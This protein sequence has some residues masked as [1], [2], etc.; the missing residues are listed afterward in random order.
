[1]KLFGRTQHEE[2]A[3]PLEGSGHHAF[4]IAGGS[5]LQLP[6]G[7]NAAFECTASRASIFLICQTVA[8]LPVHLFAR[9]EGNERERASDHPA[10]KLIAHRAA[11]WM[12]AAE[13]RREMT[14]DA[15]W[16]GNA[17][18]RVIRI[19]DAVRELQRIRPDAITLMIDQDSGEV[20]YKLRLADGGEELL[21]Y[22]EILHLQALRARSTIKDIMGAIELALALEGHGRKVFKNGAMPSGI[23]RVPTKLS[24]ENAK[25]I[26]DS[27]AKRHSGETSGGIAVLEDGVSFEPIGMSSTD[28]EH[29][30][31]RQLQIEEIARGF[32]VP[33]ILIQAYGRATWANVSEVGRLLLQYGLMPW[34]QAWQ[35]AYATAL[36]TEDEQESH[37]VEFNADAVS[38]G[39]L[40]SRYEAF[41]KA[42]A[43]AAWMT[44]NE[45]RA[46]DNRPPING[47]DEL[48]QPL[49]T[50]AQQQVSSNE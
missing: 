25:K 28:A 18:A 45:L 34:L 42:G 8:T 20:G 32:A 6:T 13:F 41:A 48:R 44:P 47:G 40:K 22:R 7:L 36:L 2:K 39:D 5:V 4:F 26:A 27:F 35:D 17:F 19:G 33:P 16:Q 15:L 24:E 9:G 14:L 12:T 43:G 31:Q 37:F 21:S 38:K 23:L 11:P 49:N 10:E 46:L 1:M 50:S 3:V 30:A 29:N